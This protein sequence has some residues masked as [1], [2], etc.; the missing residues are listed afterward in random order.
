M[1]CILLVTHIPPDPCVQLNQK[2]IE[3]LV[4][5]FDQFLYNLESLLFYFLIYEEYTEENFQLYL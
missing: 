4:L 2:W 1:I 3:F 5:V